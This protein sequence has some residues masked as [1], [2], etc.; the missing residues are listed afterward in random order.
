MTDI[1][2]F[3][4][5]AQIRGAHAADPEYLTAHFGRFGPC[6]C[7][8]GVSIAVRAACCIIPTMTLRQSFHQKK[9][10]GAPRNAPAHR[11]C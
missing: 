2:S 11:I 4:D 9:M 3:P 1:F 5:K 7:H 6:V 8:D 10:A